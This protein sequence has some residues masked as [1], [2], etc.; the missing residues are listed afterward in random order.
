MTTLTVLLW[1]GLS[2]WFC[3][4]AGDISHYEAIIAEWEG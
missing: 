2:I 4:Y 3:V 1:K